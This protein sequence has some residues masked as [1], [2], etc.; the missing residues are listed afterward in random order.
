MVQAEYRMQRGLSVIMSD[1]RT[2]LQRTW[3]RTLLQSNSL[4]SIL[5]CFL[6]IRTNGGIGPRTVRENNF[7]DQVINL[8]FVLTSH[9][10]EVRRRTMLLDLELFDIDLTVE[11]SHYYGLP[12]HR[13][14][15]CLSDDFAICMTRFNTRELRRIM[16]CFDLQGYI[17]INNGHN[18]CYTMT[19]EEIF[20]FSLTKQLAHGYV[21][22]YAH[23]FGG[24]P[25]RWKYAYKYF[26]D[27]YVAKFTHVL[28]FEGLRYEVPHLPK[29]ARQ[30]A[31]KINQ[32]V[33]RYNLDTNRYQ[34]V[35]NAITVDV[36]Q[37]RIA[38]LTDGSLYRSGIPGTGSDGHYKG[39]PRKRGAD[40]K[41]R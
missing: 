21:D 9:P 36:E 7:Y 32:P 41:Q 33:L 14:I 22:M 35:A 27:Y 19:G 24:C 16:S 2:C 37:F 29:Y 40:M 6:L 31:R 18:H 1:V 30:M 23:V 28:S 5:I 17:N 26:L 13:K 39:S 38:S 20:L 11:N 8:L 12:K 15:E 4:H 34:E 25:T 10:N 3:T